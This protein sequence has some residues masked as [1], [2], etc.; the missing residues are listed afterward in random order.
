VTDVM[1]HKRP[2]IAQ[3]DMV[4]SPTLYKALRRF[5]AGIEAVISTVKRVC[6][7]GRCRWRGKRAF[8]AYVWSSVVA[9]NFLAL[10]RRG[11]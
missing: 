9:A 3:E 7:A 10:A 5:R 4:S 1:F 8:A 6:G 2:G 11:T